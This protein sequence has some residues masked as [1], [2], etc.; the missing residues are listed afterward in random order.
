MRRPPPRLDLGV[1]G[2]GHLVPG[3][4]FGW[5]AVVALV[6]VP[7]VGL[8]DAVRGL[9]L[10]ELRDV[11]EH[12]PLAVRVL[13]HAAVAP[14]RLGDQDAPHGRRPDHPGRVELDEL[15]VDQGPAGL[16]GQGV[17]V[18]RVLPRVGGDLPGLADPAGGQDH[19]RRLEDDEAPRLPPVRKRPGDAPPGCAGRVARRASLCAGRVA[20]RASLFQ[21]PGHGALH[22]HVDPERHRVLLQGPDHLEPGPVAD[23]GQAG[24]A[25]AA[26]VP[27]ADQALLGPVEQRPPLLQLPHPLRRLLGVQL[28]HPP[29][30]EQL[31]AAH[32]VAEVNL[33]VVLGVQVAHG[34]GDAAFRHHRVGLAEQALAD[35]G[36]PGAGLVGSDRR[37]EPG[38]A[39]PDHDD[40]VGVVFVF[41]HL[42]TPILRR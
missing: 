42:L 21:K 24:V 14:D 32:G 5:P 17:P 41:A 30:V 1:D 13:E 34:R 25:V 39:G 7:A 10:E 11:V 29:V 8:F 37:P 4:Q 20:R 23:V 9:G 3:Q 16:H 15:H 36:G 2:P 18:A 38:A 28:G 26:E 31:A 6:G 12:E 22:E 40:V 33:P 19:R 35:H 27:L